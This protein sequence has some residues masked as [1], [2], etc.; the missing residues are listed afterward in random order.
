[1]LWREKDFVAV[2]QHR[3]YGPLGCDVDFRDRREDSDF[4][5]YNN[6]LQFNRFYVFDSG[7]AA[8]VSTADACFESIFTLAFI[9]VQPFWLV[10]LSRNRQRDYELAFHPP[11]QGLF[12][13]FPLHPGFC[14]YMAE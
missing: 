14:R 9:S 8:R 6:V 13:N 10:V 7:H 12:Q 3:G 2:R 1:M 5:A 11:R 4:R